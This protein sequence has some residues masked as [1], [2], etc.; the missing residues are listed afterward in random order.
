LSR[1]MV[2][3]WAWL[4]MNHRGDQD[5]ELAT[6]TNAE[7]LERGYMYTT[8][9]FILNEAYTLLRRRVHP[10]RAIDFGREIQKIIKTGAMELIYITP[11]M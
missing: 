9:N 5:H 11:E 4:A 3:T 7:L 8:T 10:Q 6:L 1:I 2:D